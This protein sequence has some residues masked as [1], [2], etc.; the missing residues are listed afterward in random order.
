MDGCYDICSAEGS[1]ATCRAVELLREKTYED[2]DL[3]RLRQLL[4]T[5]TRDTYVW[6]YVKCVKYLKH[7]I[8]ALDG[9]A[10]LC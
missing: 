2:R 5:Q 9:L 6:H 10:M 8:S 3:N 4:L 7:A 1:N